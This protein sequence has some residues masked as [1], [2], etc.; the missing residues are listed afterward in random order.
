[1]RVALGLGAVQLA[2]TL[3]WMAYAYFQ[4]RILADNGLARFDTLLAAYIAAAGGMLG[5]LAGGL[6]DLTLRRAG[7]R[8]PVILA[9]GLLAGVLFVAVAL[10]IGPHAPG[11]LRSAIPVLIAL[12]VAAMTVLQAPALALVG[13]VAGAEL[14]PVTVAPLVVATV[15]PLALWPWVQRVLE[16]AGGQMAFV[17]G[18]VTVVAATLLVR[19]WVP[20]P[21]TPAPPAVGTGSPG[22][23]YARAFALGVS[24]AFVALLAVRLVPVTLAARLERVDPSLFSGIAFAASG[25][26]APPLGRAAV[27][28]GRTRALLA[29]FVLAAVCALW[30]RVASGGASVAVLMLVLGAALA[31]HLDCALPVAFGVGSGARAGLAAGLYLGGVMAGSG[32]ALLLVSGRI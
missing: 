15:L 24:S 8:F 2:V 17:L 31:L 7:S 30:A 28:V 20:R 32:A 10:A 12:W 23:T 6:A 11:P 1:M 29:S 9:G 26:L 5:P 4:P 25:V 3:G 14:L 13:D 22:V 19:R 16:R 18:G 27:T 21:A